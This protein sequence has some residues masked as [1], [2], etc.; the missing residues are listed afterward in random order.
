[1]LT[2]VFSLCIASCVPKLLSVATV[3]QWQ[4]GVART[5]QQAQQEPKDYLLEEQF[6]RVSS[7][8]GVQLLEKEQ[9]KWSS[10]SL[11]CFPD[12]ANIRQRMP[13][14]LGL[15]RARP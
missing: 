11:V 10:E 7:R 13:S 8:V 4:G 14:G 1:M 2:A 15:L 12:G 9:H 6:A 5:E 3:A